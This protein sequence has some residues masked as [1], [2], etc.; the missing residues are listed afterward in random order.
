MD[1]RSTRNRPDTTDTLA[2]A[3]FHRAMAWRAASGR[4]DDTRLSA[5]T[6]AV[7]ALTLDRAELQVDGRQS[8]WA[9]IHLSS[10]SPTVR[11]G[12]ARRT[13]RYSANW[14]ASSLLRSSASSSAPWKQ[15]RPAGDRVD[16]D[17]N[18]NLEDP[19]SAFAQRS[20][21]PDAHRAKN[22]VRSRVTGGSLLLRSPPIHRLTREHSIEIWRARQDSNLQPSDP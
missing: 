20:L 14:L 15:N 21:A 18:A 10:S 8:W 4:S 7:S 13:A 3:S 9:T 11:N 12:A 1:E 16:A 2:P 5:R 6:S 22:R 19:C 17:R